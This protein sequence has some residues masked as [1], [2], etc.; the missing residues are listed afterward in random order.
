VIRDARRAAGGDG[1]R[2]GDELLRLAVKRVAG[3]RGS[4]NVEGE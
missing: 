1:D 3:M 4:R 2:E